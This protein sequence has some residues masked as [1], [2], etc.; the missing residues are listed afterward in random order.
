MHQPTQ[1]PLKCHLLGQIPKKHIRFS[2]AI[3]EFSSF[4]FFFFCFLP[5]IPPA[6]PSPVYVRPAPASNPGKTPPKTLTTTTVT[7][8][9]CTPTRVCHRF[10]CPLHSLRVIL[11]LRF[12]RIPK[13]RLL[14]L[15]D[16]GEIRIPKLPP[17]L[18]SG[19]FPPKTPLFRPFQS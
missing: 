4:L 16:T 14:T 13:L 7:A 6:P 5:I 3:R 8:R 19:V 12:S 18:T 9:T 17:E 15:F 10:L 1:L 11:P 2:A